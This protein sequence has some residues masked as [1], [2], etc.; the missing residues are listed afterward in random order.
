M[1][2]TELKIQTVSGLIRKAPGIQKSHKYTQANSRSVRSKGIYVYKNYQT[3]IVVGFEHGGYPY[4]IDAAGEQLQRFQ[5]FA[6]GLGFKFTP[7][8]GNRFELVI[9][10]AAK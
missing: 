7:V 4:L 9:K 5:D 8:Q 6:T 2:T 3:E 1:T 10:K